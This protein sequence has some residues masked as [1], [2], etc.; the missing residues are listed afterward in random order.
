VDTIASE[1]GEKQ[2]CDVPSPSGRAGSAAK[3]KQKQLDGGRP[4][5]KKNGLPNEG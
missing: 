5:S 2:I 1:S 3:Q 4:Y